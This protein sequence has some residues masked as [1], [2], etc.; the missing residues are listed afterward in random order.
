MQ[1]MPSTLALIVISVTNLTALPTHLDEVWAPVVCLYVDF[2]GLEEIPES[3][4]QLNVL[5]YSFVGNRIG[6]MPSF[7]AVN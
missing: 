1:P 4:F 5:S 3:V 2:S 7:D 6:H